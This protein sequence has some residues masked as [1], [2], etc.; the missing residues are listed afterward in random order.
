MLF[1]A[2]SLSHRSSVISHQS[3][4]NSQQSTVNYNSGATGIDIISKTRGS[5]T[6]NRNIHF[7]YSLTRQ[8]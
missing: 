3:L 4:V 8:G 2:K 7:L 5:P 6:V 1:W